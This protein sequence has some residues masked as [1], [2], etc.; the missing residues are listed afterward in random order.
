VRLRRGR[1]GSLDTYP[2][3]VEAIRTF[4]TLKIRE[5]VLFFVGENGSGKSTLLEALALAM[6]FGPE[7]GTRNMSF[8]TRPS[9][10][11]TN[12]EE[13]LLEF[14]D[15]LDVARTKRTRDGF[16]LRAESFF[17]VATTIDELDVQRSYGG[18]SLHNRSHGESFMTLALERFGPGGFFLLDE[19]EAALSATRQMALMARMNDLLVA[20]P[21]TQFVIAT[22]SPILLAFPDA[23]IISFDGGV[24]H[25]IAYHDSDPYVITRRFI[26]HPEA[27]LRTLFSDG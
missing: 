17:N 16:F 9:P 27:M 2:L 23:Q 1:I 12:P 8:S 13:P 5:R 18:I 20:D 4:D 22:H 7:G 21:E 25:E 3:T 14:A 11:G 15:A 6:G 19:P 26:E 24:M 10:E